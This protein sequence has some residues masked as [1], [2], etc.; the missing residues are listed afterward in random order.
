M[1]TEQLERNRRTQADLYGQDLRSLLGHVIRALGLTQAQLASTIGV[2][3][4]MLSQLMSAH[5]VKIGNP[6][7][8]Q[9]IHALADLAGEADAGRVGPTELASRLDEVRAFSGNFT[10][11][12]TDVN[13]PA[14][15]PAAVVVTAVRNLLRAVAS[16]YELHEVSRALAGDHP[17][18]AELIR[19]YGVGRHEDALAHFD[20]YGNLS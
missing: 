17:G 11:P 14:D 7:A 9:R 10:R 12:S 13:L 4:P 8:L 1:E 5:R 3:A 20:R 16:G 2:S 19:V 15:V 18:L 6:A